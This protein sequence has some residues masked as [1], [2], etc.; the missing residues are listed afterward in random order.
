[1][2]DFVKA[3]VVVDK[4]WGDLIKAENAAGREVEMF[5]DVGY[6]YHRPPSPHRLPALD[7][8]LDGLREW[9]EALADVL[10][11]P[12][13]D[14]EEEAPGYRYARDEAVEVVFEPGMAPGERPV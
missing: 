6:P 3:G 7:V 13:S 4:A 9:E 1:M 8:L 11:S 14:S 10:T 5:G 12:G 2:R